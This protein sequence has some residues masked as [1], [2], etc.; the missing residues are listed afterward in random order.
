MLMCTDLL[1]PAEGVLTQSQTRCCENALSGPSG[2]PQGGC[3]SLPAPDRYCS[4]VVT[5]GAYI[6]HRQVKAMFTDCMSGSVN[7]HVRLEDSYLK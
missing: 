5:P 7:L 3:R 2:T 6:C 1:L 4:G